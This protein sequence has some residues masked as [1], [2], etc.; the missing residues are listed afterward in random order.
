MLVFASGVWSSEGLSM[1]WR[2]GGSVECENRLRMSRS[3]TR[4]EIV[5][6]L[7]S[8]CYYLNAIRTRNVESRLL[9]IRLLTL[10]YSNGVQLVVS[11]YL[12]RLNSSNC[13]KFSR[14]IERIEIHLPD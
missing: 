11:K 2:S 9:D 4:R 5:L 14:E 3:L 10:G 7:S 13:A 1:A 12:L 8:E 6:E